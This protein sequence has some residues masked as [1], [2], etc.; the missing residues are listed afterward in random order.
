ML[1]VLG[2]LGVLGSVVGEVMGKFV[3]L[4]PGVGVAWGLFGLKFRM[5]E[6]TSTEAT[7]SIAMRATAAAMIMSFR[8]FLGGGGGGGGGGKSMLSL[9]F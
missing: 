9:I 5:P 4:G 1:I 8:D 6:K 7:S 3:G 2:V